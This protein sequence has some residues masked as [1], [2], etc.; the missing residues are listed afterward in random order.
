M[1][2]HCASL[3]VNRCKHTC[4]VAPDIWGADV[5]NEGQPAVRA[6]AAQEHFTGKSQVAR[7][8][9]PQ[10]H[11]CLCGEGWFNKLAHMIFIPVHPSLAVLNVNNCRV[12]VCIICLWF[13]STEMI[14][15][16]IHHALASLSSNY[17]IQYVALV[18]C[19]LLNSTPLLRRTDAH[20]IHG[21]TDT[22]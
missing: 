4:L 11:I 22:Y 14:V 19:M 6:C 10:R 16:M 5:L 9:L 3:H 21:N 20:L 2:I 12:I 13:D 15:M 7:S 1:C 8:L 17:Y 18:H